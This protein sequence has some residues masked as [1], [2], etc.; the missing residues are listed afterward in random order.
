[1]F[2]AKKWM[3]IVASDQIRKYCGQNKYHIII[4]MLTNFE[5]R[6]LV[7]QSCARVKGVLRKIQS[8]TCPLGTLGQDWL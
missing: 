1:M 3:K 4:A 8:F 2:S 7:N 5:S 6:Y